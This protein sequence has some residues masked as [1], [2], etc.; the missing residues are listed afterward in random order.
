MGRDW[1][2][3]Q[4]QIEGQAIPGTLTGTYLWTGPQQFSGAWTGGAGEF[5][6][7]AGNE[8]SSGTGQLKCNGTTYLLTEGTVLG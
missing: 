2:D 5:A 4:D 1:A 8:S 7:G 6:L 3:L